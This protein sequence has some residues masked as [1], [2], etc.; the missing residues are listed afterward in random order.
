MPASSDANRRLVLQGSPKRSALSVIPRSKTISN[1]ATT[2]RVLAKAISTILQM[3]LPGARRSG[4]VYFGP[5]RP[6]CLWFDLVSSASSQVVG[7][8]GST[9]TNRMLVW[10]MLLIAWRSCGWPQSIGIA[11]IDVSSPFSALCQT[12][13]EPFIVPPE[14]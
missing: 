2:T 14:H 7:E 13:A 4:L 10:F 8:L 9:G 5:A 3:A 12:H 6:S 1:N 11:M